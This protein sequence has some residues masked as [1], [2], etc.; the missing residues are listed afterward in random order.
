MFHSPNKIS[1]LPM[2]SHLNDKIHIVV[3]DCGVS[4]DDSIFGAGFTD[5]YKAPSSFVDDSIWG[6]IP[7]MD[8]NV[9]K[10]NTDLG[11]S[12]E[13]S[14]SRTIPKFP[15]DN[16]PEGYLIPKLGVSVEFLLRLKNLCISLYGE[17]S[18][19]KIT[20][21]EVSK[22]LFSRC[23]TASGHADSF[24]TSKETLGT[25]FSFL[26]HFRSYY[27]QVD[28]PV[29][30]FACS[31]AL[32]SNANIYVTHC[33]SNTFDALVDALQEFSR[34]HYSGHE[35]A[36][37]WLDVF[38]SV[39]EL[40][41]ES[42]INSKSSRSLHHNVCLHALQCIGKVCLLLMPWSDPV[43]LRNARCLLELL[44]SYSSSC[45]LFI[46]LSKK[47]HQSYLKL[48]SVNYPAAENAIE[49]NIRTTFCGDYD[50]DSLADVNSTELKAI[51]E[52]F[53]SFHEGE[54]FA[55]VDIILNGWLSSSRITAAIKESTMFLQSFDDEM[56]L[57]QFE[58]KSQQNAIRTPES[59]SILSTSLCSRLISFLENIKYLIFP[60]APHNPLDRI[61]TNRR[62]IKLLTIK[63]RANL[64]YLL[65]KKGRYSEAELL[66]KQLL[67]DQLMQ[68]PS[69]GSR[70]E[71]HP[72]ALS[73]TGNLALL[74][75]S[76]GRDRWEEAE[77]LYRRVLARKKLVLGALH[78]STLT[79]TYNLAVLLEK[80]PSRRCE[81]EGILRT[82]LQQQKVALGREHE[83]CMRSMETLVGILLESEDSKTR[84]DAEA[85]ESTTSALSL[86]QE[87]LI[88]RTDRW[89]AYHH[90][91]LSTAEVLAGVYLQRGRPDLAVDLYE[92]VCNYFDSK[93][94]IFSENV[95]DLVIIYK[96]R[97]R[98]YP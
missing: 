39:D 90:Q 80:Q 67:R 17:D 33:W 61:S 1:P 21:K 54:G 46:Q 64:A 58:I 94:S 7:K 86:L 60:G 44:V 31:P 51:K 3:E 62:E 77:T 41:G 66:Y 34:Q 73:A 45:E 89:G 8:S 52:K 59:A 48:C 36:F 74:L 56:S 43:A 5:I 50:G 81:A 16:I 95:I 97:F 15:L 22:R 72:L 28:H 96:N 25:P 47:R 75:Q 68:Q 32:V 2:E 23:S 71:N 11:G 9:N 92:E 79:T 19:G 78:P 70:P 53:Q 65:H 57:H 24:S 12:V 40:A 85:E 91:T 83:D 38:L 37:F 84:N 49:F 26:E 93:I 10:Q 4:N 18:A 35:T 42:L 14:N 87:L 13:Y 82:L 55:A 20:T 27:S 29:V 76:Q 88:L 6:F 98:S 63:V 30:G 69:D